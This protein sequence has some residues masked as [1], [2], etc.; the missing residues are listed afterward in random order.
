MA[1]KLDAEKK[2][3]NYHVNKF[4]KESQ[5][6]FRKGYDPSLQEIID[7]VNNEFPSADFKQVHIK[8]VDFNFTSFV[9]IKIL[10]EQ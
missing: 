1:K 3:K 7:A 5:I 2:R 10:T 6:N 8:E 4:L 9:K